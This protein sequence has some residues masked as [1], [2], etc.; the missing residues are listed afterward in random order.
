VTMVP[1]DWRGITPPSNR[2]DSTAELVKWMGSEN[3][4]M[5]KFKQHSR[6]IYQT[7]SDGSERVTVLRGHVTVVDSDGGTFEI[8]AGQQ[9]TVKPEQKATDGIVANVKLSELTD[10]I[11]AMPETGGTP[12]GGNPG[13]CGTSAILLLIPALFVLSRK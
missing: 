9:Y 13:C 2:Q 3:Y 10:E 11:A 5:K 6:V 8:G 12:P 4:N 7:L 1:N